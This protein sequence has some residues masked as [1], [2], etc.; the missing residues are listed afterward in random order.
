MFCNPSPRSGLQ[1]LV[2]WSER[3]DCLLPIL[4]LPRPVEGGLL[5]AGCCCWGCIF[6]CFSCSFHLVATA[7]VWRAAVG[8]GCCTT[9]Y[10][11][12]IL[13]EIKTQ[14]L[15]DLVGTRYVVEEQVKGWRIAH[16]NSGAMRSENPQK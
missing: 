2:A 7:T 12:R 3:H 4:Q 5:A 8:G 6:S 1:L 14:L 9:A 13:E 15:H 11:G 10:A 16:E